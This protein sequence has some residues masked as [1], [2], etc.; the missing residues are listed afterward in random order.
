[1]DYTDLTPHTKGRITGM[2]EAAD[3]LTEQRITHH[4]DKLEDG[5][6][7]V[8]RHHQSCHNTCQNMARRIQRKAIDLAIE[9]ATNE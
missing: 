5:R 9:E 6:D 7:N 2:L 8:R 3:A 4:T 1:M